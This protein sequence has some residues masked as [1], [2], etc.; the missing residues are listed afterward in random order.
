MRSRSSKAVGRFT[1]A[2]IHLKRRLAPVQDSE[3]VR[4]ASSKFS[5]HRI[6][7][8]TLKNAVRIAAFANLAY[9]GVEC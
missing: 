6:H 5:H 8:V 4:R 7:P 1:P 9:F 3:S 2:T